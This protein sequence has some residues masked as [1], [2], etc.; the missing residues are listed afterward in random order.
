M[1]TLNVI[2][3]KSEN[4]YSAY[5]EGIDGIVGVGKDIEDVKH[6]IINSIKVFIESCKELGCD[7]PQELKEEFTLVYKTE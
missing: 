2:I 7:I 4:N 6:S 5:L 1:R 3:E